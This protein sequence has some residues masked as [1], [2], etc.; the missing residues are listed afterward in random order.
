VGNLTAIG[1]YATGRV[2]GVNVHSR[3]GG[4]GREAIS[5][6]YRKWGIGR[7]P[8][9]TMRAAAFRTMDFVAD[10]RPPARR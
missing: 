9:S 6:E 3:L 8:V 1:P 7:G 2:F 4:F 10:R 5:R